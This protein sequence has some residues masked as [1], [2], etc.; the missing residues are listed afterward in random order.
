MAEYR[1]H[2][3]Y[4]ETSHEAIEFIADANQSVKYS[5]NKQRL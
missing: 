4:S 3:R 1:H 2:Y 5:L